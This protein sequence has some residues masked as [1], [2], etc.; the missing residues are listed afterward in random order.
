[1]AVN[2]ELKELCHPQLSSRFFVLFSK[3]ATANRL[4]QEKIKDSVFYGDFCG[5]TASKTFKS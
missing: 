3:N 4:E 1:M 5:T 2:E